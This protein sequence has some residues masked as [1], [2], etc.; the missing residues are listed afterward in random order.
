M[1][2]CVVMKKVELMKCLGFDEVDLF[3]EITNSFIEL[4][5]QFRFWGGWFVQG[6]NRPVLLCGKNI[7]IYT[8]N[9]NKKEISDTQC[10]SG[11]F[12]DTSH[13]NR[14]LYINSST[15]SLY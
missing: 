10:Y 15:E 5:K 14:I 2:V 13:Q 12:M 6:N 4:N 3:K 7:H 9:F 8:L 11:G 1:S